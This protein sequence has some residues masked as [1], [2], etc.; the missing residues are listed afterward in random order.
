M[1]VGPG[2]L[3]WLVKGKRVAVM[4]DKGGN[5]SEYVVIPARQ[6]RPV[7]DDLPDEQVAS[8]FVN[9]ASVLAMVRHVLAVP[10]GEWLLQSA[11]GSA[12]GRMVIKLA[13]HDGIKTVN[14]VRRP[15]AID[16]L[17]AL[18]ADVVI[19]SSDGPIAE[20]VRER[21]GTDGVRYA[22]DPVGGDTGTGV[23][24]SLAADGRMLVYGTLS[25]RAAADRPPADD[26][27]QAGRRGILARPLGPGAEHPPD[28]PAVPRDRGD[29]PRRG[30]RHGGRCHLPPGSRGRCRPSGRGRRP[31][32]QGAPEAATS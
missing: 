20:Q 26:R 2:L 29:D 30:P 4:N 27:R 5:W 3:G 22:L 31:A 14:V 19:S 10:R 25:E 23:F 7:A 8:F 24:E 11:A 16:E 12:L 21:T 28:A 32:R 18:G 6:A 9:P 15:E 13:R 17:K 1:Q